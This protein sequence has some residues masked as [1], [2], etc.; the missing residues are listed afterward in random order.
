MVHSR[1]GL[2]FGNIGFEYQKRNAVDD[3]RLTDMWL[4]KYST[5]PVLAA[6]ASDDLGSVA[7]AV[8]KQ[9]T[10]VDVSGD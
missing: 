7:W 1:N 4:E 2:H 10:P 6:A 8:E 9:S 3:L 5:P